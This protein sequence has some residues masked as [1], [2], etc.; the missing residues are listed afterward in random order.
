MEPQVLAYYLED[1]QAD[2]VRAF[3]KDN[4]L[5]GVLSLM[6]TSKRY[7]LYSSVGSHL[8]GFMAQTEDSGENKVGRL[9]LERAYEDELSG[10]AGRVVTA[11]T[12]RGFQM[13]SSYENY[14]DAEDGVVDVHWEKEP[15]LPI[16][17]PEGWKL[18][19]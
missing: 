13:L 10:Q 4:K 7:Y 19:K 17:L 2:A 14:L 1:E 8:L 18:R 12:G 16:I 15:K 6:P 11:T 5:S 3:I 9:G